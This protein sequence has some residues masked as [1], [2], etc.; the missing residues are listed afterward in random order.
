MDNIKIR[1]ETEK[2]YRAVE[3]LTREEQRE[4]LSLVSKKSA[5]VKELT[6]ILLDGGLRE[7]ERFEDARQLFEQ[8]AC[9]FEEELECDFRLSVALMFLVRNR[10]AR[11]VYFFIASVL[12]LYIS[13]VGFRIGFGGM[14]PIQIAVGIVTALACVGAFVFYRVGKGNDKLFLVAR[15]L[16]AAALTVGFFNAIL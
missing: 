9:E 5:H 4:Y 16:T 8:L 7:V 15:I 12:G 11:K 2:D 10:T 1:L 3:E 6:D 13:W 14:F